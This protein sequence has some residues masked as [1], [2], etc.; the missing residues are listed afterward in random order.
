VLESRSAMT[1]VWLP[2]HWTLLLLFYLIADF[3]DPSV[4]GVFFFDND[5]LFVDGAIQAKSD[6]THLVT[7][8]LVPL[9]GPAHDESA[10]ATRQVVSRPSRPQYLSW[11]NLKRDDSASFASASPP[12]SSPTPPSS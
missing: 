10:A 6:T 12:D 1:S 2:R 3:T 8:E 9:G 7:T 4:P 11:K 5:A